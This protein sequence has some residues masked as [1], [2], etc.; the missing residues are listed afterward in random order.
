MIF[1]PER[2]END[3]AGCNRA[4]ASIAG[5]HEQY[6]LSGAASNRQGAHGIKEA[7]GNNRGVRCAPQFKFEHLRVRPAS[8]FVARSPAR[9]GAS[10]PSATRHVALH[11]LSREPLPSAGME[12][13]VQKGGLS[14]RWST[15]ADTAPTTI[16]RL[17]TSKASPN[18]V[19][20]DCGRAIRVQQELED[21]TL[22]HIGRDVLETRLSLAQGCL[23]TL[24]FRDLSA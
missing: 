5:G 22:R 6:A 4:V 12:S 1:S 19:D 11:R 21:Q 3:G 10:A 24:M 8:F 14:Q 15:K 17:Y 23:S 9:S 7:R 2:N 16:P 13:N 20:W 18:V